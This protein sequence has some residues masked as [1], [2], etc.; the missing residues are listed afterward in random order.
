M[1]KF[2]VSFICIGLLT[3]SMASAIMSPVRLAK[4]AFAPAKNGCTKEERATTL[5]WFLGVPAAVV[6]AALALIGVKMGLDTVKRKQD[7][8]NQELAVAIAQWSA[9]DVRTG[10]MNPLYEGKKDEK[11]GV[12]QLIDEGKEVDL[13]K[14]VGM[15]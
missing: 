15:F 11:Q 1:K 9:E 4:C 10:T 3:G 5:K 8:G 6:V 7:E 2:L 12:Q 14:E 13:S